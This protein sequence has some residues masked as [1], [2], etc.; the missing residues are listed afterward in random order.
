MHTKIFCISI[1]FFLSF[2]CIYSQTGSNIFPEPHTETAE[3]EIILKGAPG[4]NVWL[5]GVYGDQNLLKDSAQADTTGKVVFKNKRY[6]EGMYYAAYRDN[7][8]LAFLLDRNQKIFL[9]TDKA[10]VNRRMETNSA[11]NKIYYENR[12]YEAD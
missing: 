11:E 8:N 3:I 5:F 10:D 2:T 6:S 9:H 4:G 12:A 1:A 7:S